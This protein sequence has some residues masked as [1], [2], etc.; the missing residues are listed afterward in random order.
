M[1]THAVKIS[2]LVT[3]SRRSVSRRK[4]DRRA[5]PQV[6][7]HLD[8]SSNDKETVFSS[9]RLWK[10]KNRLLRVSLEYIYPSSFPASHDTMGS[11]QEFFIFLLRE[12]DRKQLFSKLR[13]TL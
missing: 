6:P 13:R 5:L 1:P 4:N 8:T 11:I 12:S 3:N 10:F 2:F 7:W 9:K